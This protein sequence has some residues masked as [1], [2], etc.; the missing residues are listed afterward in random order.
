MPHLYEKNIVEIK[1]EYTTFLV[2]ILR[3]CIYQQFLSTY[4]HAQELEQEC[5]TKAKY[6]P[7]VDNPG[8]LKFFQ[9]AL[10]DVPTTNRDQIEK[11]VSKIKE[12][13][14][15]AD[16]FDDL[17]KAVVKSNIILL[18]YTASKNQSN[19]VKDKYHERIDICDFVHK[20]FIETATD[21]YNRPELFWHDLPSLEI[22]KNQI[23]I[24]AIIQSAILNAIRKILPV[25][26]ILQEY[27]K[28][29]YADADDPNKH[30][31]I[32]AEKYKEIEQNVKKEFPDKYKEQEKIPEKTVV[33]EQE[34]KT[35]LSPESEG[36]KEIKKED[37]E[38]NM[39]DIKS[40]LQNIGNS[41]NNTNDSVESNLKKNRDITPEIP[42][43]EN[44]PYENQP[45]TQQQIGGNNN[46][47][48]KKYFNQYF[49]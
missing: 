48:K 2:N 12:G 36:F 1:N 46:I 35:P 32:P 39:E 16:W 8:V 15:C 37:Y 19:I 10:K 43:L 34:Y 45:Q 33:P 7:N 4:K 40:K 27:L 49:K 29:D 5:I 13:C 23:E 9:A 22:K 18:T 14:K 20:C 38:E 44:K 17:V 28:N 47:I 6:N 42:S 41:D 11:I 26:L 25:K 31:E 21:I 30:Y 3:P 24:Y